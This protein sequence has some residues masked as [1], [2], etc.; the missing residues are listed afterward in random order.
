MLT[1]RGCAGRERRRAL[2]GTIRHRP[3]QIAPEAWS[4][5]QAEAELFA[6]CD[7]SQRR[8]CSR[9][10]QGPEVGQVAVV[11]GRAEHPTACTGSAG[12]QGQRVWRVY[13]RAA[14]RGWRASDLH[15]TRG[16]GQP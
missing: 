2:A 16:Q 1:L 5:R 9:T 12:T 11:A 7:A 10:R 14:W 13:I 3:T 4:K 8:Q 6:T 15:A